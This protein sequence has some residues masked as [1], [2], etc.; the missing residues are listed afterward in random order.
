MTYKREKASD[1]NKLF[2]SIKWL[3][4]VITGI[5]TTSLIFMLGPVSP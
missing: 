3:L 1:E 2:A 5:L 4:T